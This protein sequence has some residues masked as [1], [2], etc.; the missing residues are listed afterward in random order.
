MNYINSAH[1][2]THTHIDVKRKAQNR[3]AIKTLMKSIEL[4]IKLYRAMKT[5]VLFA[6]L[7]INRC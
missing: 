3:S 7:V 4:N 6:P 1:I 2:D 5:T